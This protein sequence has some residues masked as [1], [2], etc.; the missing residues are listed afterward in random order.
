MGDILHSLSFFLQLQF[1]TPSFSSPLNPRRS[2][3]CFPHSGDGGADFLLL[4][5]VFGTCFG[6]DTL[7]DLEDLASSPCLIIFGAG[8]CLPFG[9]ACVAGDSVN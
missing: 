5:I 9:A 2:V 7:L 4:C 8:T 3:F 1:L 6:F